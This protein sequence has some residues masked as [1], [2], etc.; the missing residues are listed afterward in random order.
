MNRKIPTRGKRAPNGA[1]SI[2]QDKNG[3][4]HG[5]VTMGVR[6]D[7]KIDRRHVESW[8][9][10]TV[11]D[12]V[13]KLERARDE[14]NVTKPGLRWTVAEWIEHWLNNI[15]TATTSANGWDAYYYATKHI[16][17]HVGAHKLPNLLPDHLESMY[18]K[19]QDSGSAAGTAN[20]VHRTARTALN[21]A[22][23]RGY[24]AK[25][26]A[27]IAKPP[28]VEEEEIEPFTR[29]EITK[30]FTV[31][32]D[33]RNAC[34]WVVAIALGLRQGEVLGLR[35]QDV[36]FHEGTLTVAIQRPRPK[37]RHG[38]DQPCG[39]KHAGHCPR[40]VNTRKETARPKS[41]AGRRTIGLPQ[42]LLDQLKLHL[43][44]QGKEREKAAELWDEQGWLFTNEVGRPLNHRTDLARW[45]QLL[46]AA[47]VRDARLHDA[48]HTAATVLLELGVPD[49]AAMQIM[50]WS[51]AA[52]TQR[53][54]HVTGHVLGSVATQVGA[55]LWE[56]PHHAN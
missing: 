53:Y 10:K 42:P 28:R 55:H 15:A 18:R 16:T 19:M 33:G 26:P 35:W 37:W 54:Q 36:D 46:E 21:E 24:L 32:L 22:V 43:I 5:R 29:D 2:Y 13:R 30:I 11:T 56:T 39:H 14:G 17:K 1:S 34:R 52:L 23:V 31:A 41:K 4:W 51:N 45:K 6:D 47:G 20:Q 38:C 48:R 7:G 9:R 25:N 40:R 27:L 8:D 12:K 44:E 50:G 3:K 49:R